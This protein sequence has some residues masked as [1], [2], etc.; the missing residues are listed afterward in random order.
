MSID[1]AYA[2]STATSANASVVLLRRNRGPQTPPA[3]QQTPT[4]ATRGPA[5]PLGS[6]PSARFAASDAPSAVGA[7][8]GKKSAKPTSRM[9]SKTEVAIVVLR[10][11]WIWSSSRYSVATLPPSRFHVSEWGV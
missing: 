3:T 9:R 1:T 5:S 4:N 6:H 11:T 10:A 7:P 8:R 2:A